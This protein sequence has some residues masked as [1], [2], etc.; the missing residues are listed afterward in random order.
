[1]NTAEIRIGRLV[2][3]RVDAGY[4]T[5]DEVHALFNAIG[6]AVAGRREKRFV[7]VVDWR[8]C[9]VMSSEATQCAL[10]EMTRSN[11]RVERSAAVTS[12]HSPTAVLQFLRL[13]RE[14][15]NDDR[16]LFRDP[17]AL[18]AWLAEVLVPE[19]TVRLRQFLECG[20]ER[21]TLPSIRTAAAHK[22]SPARGR[23]G[24]PGLTV[25]GRTRGKTC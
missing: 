24:A 22:S 17:D 9:P 19:E 15:N 7:T 2:E 13:V 5:V 23:P 25:G 18:V 8:R 4:R 6:L 12:P 11:P 16:R 10:Q 21:T 3:V 14:S 1:M 20:A